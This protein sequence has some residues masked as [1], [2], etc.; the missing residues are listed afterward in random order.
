MSNVPSDDGIPDFLRRK[1]VPM[2][3][4]SPAKAKAKA[5]PA[6]VKAKPVTTPEKPIKGKD[7]KLDQFGYRLGSKK[8]AAAALYA[9][10]KGATLEEVHKA[11]GSVQLNLL[12]DC[13][14]RGFTV[15][16][17]KENGAGKRQ[18]TRYHLSK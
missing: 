7:S 6:A 8:S 2:A 15:K 9:A 14:G 16:R 13:E 11:T 18:V 3:S 4:T 5:T 10:K 1:E 12:K 17:S